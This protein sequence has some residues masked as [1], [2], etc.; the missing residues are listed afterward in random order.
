MFFTRAGLEQATR[1]IVAGRRAARLA[2]AGVATLADL[3][4]G[5]GSDA[6]AAARAGIRCTRWTPTR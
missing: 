5:I 3:G 1:T 2:A 4:C 6:L